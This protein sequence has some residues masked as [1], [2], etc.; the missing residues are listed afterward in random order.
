M[1]YTE[2][3]YMPRYANDPQDDPD[4]AILDEQWASA[5]LVS[6]PAAI[7]SIAE[8]LVPEREGI[9]VTPYRVAVNQRLSHEQ[10][11]NKLD[12]AE[13][14]ATLGLWPTFDEWMEDQR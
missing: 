13:L 7:V 10:V 3:H 5:V 2:H 8:E 14:G 4:W 1:N 12:I 11:N 9:D 6:V